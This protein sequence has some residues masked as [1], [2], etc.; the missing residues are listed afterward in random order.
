MNIYA[1]RCNEYLKIGISKN[2]RARLKSLQTSSPYELTMEK[3]YI[4]KDAKIAESLVHM[5]LKDYHERGE[6]FKVS[7]DLVD[8]AVS[9]INAMDEDSLEYHEK[10]ML[11]K[12]KAVSSSRRIKYLKK[13]IRK[14]NEKGEVEITYGMLKG[15]MTKGMGLPRWKADLLGVRYPLKRG[16]FGK[17]IGKTI[18]IDTYNILNGA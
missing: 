1:I 18:S 15:F 7:I 3:T 17:T 14:E 13:S 6:W 2:P 11:K 5:K 16:W 9:E 10:T 12:G 8:K 4:V